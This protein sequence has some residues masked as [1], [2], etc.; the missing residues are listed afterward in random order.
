MDD[1][2]LDSNYAGSPR[3]R[4]KIVELYLSLSDYHF[5][6]G[7]LIKRDGL[8]PVEREVKVASSGEEDI[9]RM[10]EVYTGLAIGVP[11]VTLWKAFHKCRGGRE[12]AAREIEVAY[13]MYK[14]WDFE[15]VRAWSFLGIDIPTSE[16]EKYLNCMRSVVDAESGRGYGSSNAPR[17]EPIDK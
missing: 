4:P 14:K 6:L 10:T 12:L 13:V 7:R 2:K 3:K 8:L 5:L 1:L 16:E 17:C 11:T 9:A 15:P